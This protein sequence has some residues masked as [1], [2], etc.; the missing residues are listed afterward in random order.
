MFVQAIKILESFKGPDYFHL[1]GMKVVEVIEG[2]HHPGLSGVLVSRAKLLQ[3]Q[4]RDVVT[5]LVLERGSRTAGTTCFMWKH[6][7]S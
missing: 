5:F 3:Q 6:D 2:R 1:R 7:E 4:V